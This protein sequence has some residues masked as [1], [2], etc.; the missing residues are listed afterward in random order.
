MTPWMVTASS[1]VTRWKASPWPAGIEVMKERRRRR[2]LQTLP[3]AVQSLLRLAGKAAKTL[4]MESL[5]A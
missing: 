1:G 3:A 2:N 4:F 5:A